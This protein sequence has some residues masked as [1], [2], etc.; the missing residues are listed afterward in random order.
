MATS[1]TRARKNG[2]AETGELRVPE[3]HTRTVK[4]RVVGTSPLMTHCWSAKAI[5]EMEDKQQGEIKQG[6]EPKD[7]QADYEAAMYRLPDGTYGVPARAF[8]KAMVSAAGQVP[9]LTK[10]L[11][12]TVFHVLGDAVAD[13]NGPNGELRPTD[14]IR[15]HE[16]LPRMRTDMVRVGTISKSADVRYRP[17]YATWACDVTIWYNAD[18][19]SLEWLVYLLRLAGFGIGVGE[20]RPEKGGMHGMWE[21]DSVQEVA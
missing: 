3:L 20:W 16:G 15:I 21:V 7:P 8:K 14:L 6:K 2:V 4:V 11:A 17:E 1:A 10:T 5:R 9:H 19:I 18:S 13:V 12:R